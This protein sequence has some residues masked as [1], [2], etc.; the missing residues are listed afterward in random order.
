[1]KMKSKTKIYVDFETCS[2]VS[3]K[4]GVSR[5]VNDPGF[6]AYLMCYAIENGPIYSVYLPGE[7]GIPSR[8]QTEIRGP[9]EFV[10]HNGINFD[11]VVFD[12]IFKIH[13]G[14]WNDT[15]LRGAYAG[16][17]PYRSLESFGEITGVRKDMEGA[18]L[19][20]KF[21]TSIDGMTAGELK[22]IKG[23]GMQDIEA[24]RALDRVLPELDEVA[25]FIRNMILEQNAKGIKVDE[26]RLAMLRHVKDKLIAET[27]EKAK[28]FG[29][30]KKGKAGELIAYSPAQ[31]KK[32]A[33]EKCG[34]P[35]SSIDK[36]S[37]AMFITETGKK[38]PEKFQELMD[39]YSVLQS[40][41]YAK[42]DSLV[43]EGSIVKDF[44]V[45]YGA[46]TGRPAGR[47]I[48]LHNVKRS[49]DEKPFK[50]EL[51][52][53]SQLGS[54]IWACLIP[55]S[56][57]QVII[58]SDLSSIE[59]RVGAWLR[60]DKKLMKVYADY[61]SGVGKDAYTIFAEQWKVERKIAKEIILG[62]PYGMRGEA[63]H[64]KLLEGGV[65]TTI[66]QCEEFVAKFH[67]SQPDITPFQFRLC[68]ILVS[69]M[70][71]GNCQTFAGCEF[72]KTSFNKT[73][74]LGIVLPSGRVKYYVHAR[75]TQ[76]TA[77]WF[78]VV[79]GLNVFYP[80]LIYQNLVQMIAGDV[81]YEKAFQI[82]K[83][84][85]A[86]VAL[87]IYDETITSTVPKNRKAI[88]SIMNAPCPFLEGMP[89]SAKTTVSS[90]F[91]K[92]DAL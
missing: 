47:G 2:G 90:S 65:N 8:I 1:M 21:Y 3:I 57:D 39:C 17:G 41:S 29:Y 7:T 52:T 64:N 84:K 24:L 4:E 63:L 6:K 31:I 70:R 27:E 81:L 40:K 86:R 28:K 44:Q 46:Y 32:F 42:I 79:C 69:V 88:E 12:K 22:R 43:E 36:K 25:I 26:K 49:S 61:D 48:Q 35:I 51:E 87:T 60:N 55:D 75:V 77:K 30:Y 78:T 37:L 66:K 33:N 50:K 13:T 38:L 5:Y 72:F 20:E 11:S 15:I 23:Y 10:A 59:P 73:P 14:V 53:K 76:R 56:K 91:W 83:L 45:F 80:S 9:H 62:I 16:F 67:Q 89:V 92:G 71:T 19:L 68:N 54:L 82:S 18:K 85:N 58:R 74:V 34:L